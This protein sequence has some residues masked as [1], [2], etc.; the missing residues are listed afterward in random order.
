MSSFTL[1]SSSV[2]AQVLSTTLLFTSLSNASSS[3]L[4][5]TVASATSGFRHSLS[6]SSLSKP[7]SAITSESFS[8][9]LPLLS[10]RDTN[11]E[12]S[13]SLVLSC[14]Q[15]CSFMFS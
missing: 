12:C 7:F 11:S 1:S 15:S 6:T 3:S 9:H 2:A 10:F 8:E 5:P 14:A 13:S 4:V